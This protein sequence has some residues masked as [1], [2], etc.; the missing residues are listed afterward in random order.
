MSSLPPNVLGALLALLSFSV[1]ATQDALI[2]HLAADYTSNQILFFM[3]LFTFPLILLKLAFDRQQGTLIPKNL[4]LVL[5]RG[6]TG[7]TSAA[8]A[9][10]AF[11]VLPLAQVYVLLFAAPLLITVLAVPFLGEKVGLRRSIAVVVG[12]AGVILVLRPGSADFSIGHLAG[13][14]AAVLSSC[15]GILMRKVGRQERTPV[16]LF[17]VIMA[18]VLL[19][20]STMPWLYV[21]MAGRDLFFVLVAS[22]LSFFAMQLAIEAY[23]RAEAVVVA[24]MQYSQILWALFFGWLL[25]EEYPDAITLIGAAIVMSSGIYILWRES[26]DRVSATTPATVT[27]ARSEVPMAKGPKR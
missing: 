26:R 8:L 17:Y 18:S 19:T 7:A 25:F 21:P 22:L 20:G 13:L 15:S 24:P 23:R 3:G 10:Y 27:P 14:T 9:I 2:K 11:T 6:F 12:L 5:L 4:K 16:L 1:F